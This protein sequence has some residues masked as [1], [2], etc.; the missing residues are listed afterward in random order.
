MKCQLEATDLLHLVG[1]SFPHN[2]DDARSKSL[3]IFTYQEFAPCLLIKIY[4][5]PHIFCS[6]CI[7][8]EFR[9]STSSC[10]TSTE[11]TVLKYVVD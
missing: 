10:L 6:L 8:T 5:F 3:R 11:V 2:N 4:F 1:I 9:S 7:F